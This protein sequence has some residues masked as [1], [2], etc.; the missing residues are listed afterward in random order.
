V[1]VIVTEVQYGKMLR[2]IFDQIEA[3]R[4]LSITRYSLSAW[5]QGQYKSGD[6]TYEYDNA[7]QVTICVWP[8]SQDKRY[9]PVESPTPIVSPE[10][11]AAFEVRLK[12]AVANL[13]DQNPRRQ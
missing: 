11:E 9:E 6:L 13:V 12:D 2:R 8:N 3:E 1:N 4:G 10:E 7:F 5:E